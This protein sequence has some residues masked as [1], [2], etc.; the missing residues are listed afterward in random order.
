MMLPPLGNHS[1]NPFTAQDAHPR[2]FSM[3]MLCPQC[4]APMSN[5]RY[6]DYCDTHFTTASNAP[7]PRKWGTPNDA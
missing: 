4:G 6:C 2:V 3:A 5:A 7:T 1:T